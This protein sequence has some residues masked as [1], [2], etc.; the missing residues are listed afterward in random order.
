MSLPNIFKILILSAA[1][2]G[3]SSP[4]FA[5]DLRVEGSVNATSFVGDGSQLTG[6]VTQAAPRF[7]IW[8]PRTGQ[9][10]CWDEDGA[11]RD[12]TG[13]GEDG[14]Y[15][16]GGRLAGNIDWRVSYIVTPRFTDNTDGT[17]TDNLTGLIWL[18]NA[19][20][21]ADNT[22]FDNSGTPNDGMVTWQQAL[23]FVRGL[24][25]ALYDCKDGSNGGSA[26]TDW[27]MPN[28]NELLSVF[29]P[30]GNDPALPTD[31]PF[32]NVQAE[33]YW[34]SSTGVG[35][36]EKDAYIVDSGSGN[37]TGNPKSMFLYLWPVRG[38]KS[39]H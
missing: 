16:M 30:S 10:G 25:T 2:A 21:I 37:G 15:Q 29:D 22:G 14:E 28:Y 7:H 8:V 18:K 19:N 13:T 26:Q 1:I 27:R 5:G 11:S 24:N 12:C 32:S 34:S 17:V 6:V 4:L 33:R 36:S 38:G 35:V 9:T 31:H 20:C 3:L 39:L 23:D